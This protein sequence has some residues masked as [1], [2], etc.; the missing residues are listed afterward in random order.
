MVSFFIGGGNNYHFSSITFDPS[1]SRTRDI[2]TYGLPELP[3]C[4]AWNGVTSAAHLMEVLERG[5]YTP[6]HPWDWYIYLHFA[7]CYHLN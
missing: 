3:S 7:I 1:P 4:E 6:H 5:I 2:H